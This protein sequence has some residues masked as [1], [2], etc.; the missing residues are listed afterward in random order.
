[1]ASI[2]FIGLGNMG[3]PMAS[4]LRDAG[5]GLI[6][7]DM[8]H[9]HAQRFAGA[10]AARTAKEVADRTDVVLLSLP[11][12]GAVRSVALDDDG[13]AHGSRAK[14]VVDLSTTGPSSRRK[15]PKALVEKASSSSMLR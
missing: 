5:H 2:G 9:E 13:L 15:P 10:E 12:P 6:V 7:Q 8:R 14:L 4:R 1:M 3:H 11:T